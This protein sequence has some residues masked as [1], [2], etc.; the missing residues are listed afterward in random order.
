[1]ARIRMA[2]YGTKH[3]HAAGK[4]IAM[5]QNPNVEVVGVYEPDQERR[6]ELEK[7]N[8]PFRG[9]RLFRDKG[10]LLDDPSIVAVA[11]EGQNDESLKHTEELV[12]AGK[13]VW[14]DKPAG[15]NWEQWRRVVAL[16]ETKGLLIQMGYM[17]RY[18]DGFR[19]IAEWA[20]SGLLGD[21]FGIRAH[22]STNIPDWNK[23]IIS[24]HAGG[25]FYDLAGHVLDQIVW[26]LGRPQK[27]TAFLRS[28][29]RVVPG[30][31]DNTLGVF[32]YER[33]MAVC[34]HRCHGACAHGA[35]L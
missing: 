27:V 29:E 4:L 30:F 18:H 33:A 15:D 24:R 20:Q 6:A 19:R 35:S 5:L 26:I 21:I 2:Q 22:M 34:G 12:R 7:G 1:M 28:D 16:A 13:H 14:Y 23:A 25:I 17:F 3:G 9:L 8:N 32:G 11:S 31:K 10:A